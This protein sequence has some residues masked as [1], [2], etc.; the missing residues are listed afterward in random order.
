MQPTVQ[1]TV[2][3]TAQEA[4]WTNTQTCM[5]PGPCGR[6]QLNSQFPTLSLVPASAPYSQP[7]MQGAEA[8]PNR[9]GQLGVQSH[10]S[11][12]GE[13]RE[14]VAYLLRF[15]LSQLGPRKEGERMTAGQV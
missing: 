12:C 15:A 6:L 7:G 3:L 8:V 1:P 5:V 14:A 4:A 11:H 2:Q 13:R 9:A 10:P